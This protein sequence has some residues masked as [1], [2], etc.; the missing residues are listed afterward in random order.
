MIVEEVD[1]P[2]VKLDD[3]ESF[4]LTC[5][6][7]LAAATRRL[8]IHN[9][10]RRQWYHTRVGESFTIRSIVDL[11]SLVL[12]E[13]R[14][15]PFVRDLCIYDWH[16]DTDDCPCD[17]D[18]CQCENGR[19]RSKV[20]KQLT[21]ALSAHAKDRVLS[22]DD[23]RDY[24]L[25]PRDRT[26]KACKN[27]SKTLMAY[28]LPNVA[29][30]EWSIDMIDTACESWLRKGSAS[31]SNL[32]PGWPLL[33]TVNA[34]LHSEGPL[35][36][37]FKPFMRS[38]KLKTLIGENFWAWDEDVTRYENGFRNMFRKTWETQD[39]NIVF[40]E[41]YIE[42]AQIGLLLRDF[43]G[44]QLLHSQHDP[45]GMFGA[46][47]ENPLEFCP[48]HLVESIAEQ[49]PNLLILKL[50]HEPSVSC[51]IRKSLVQDCAAFKKLEHLDIP[52]AWIDTTPQSRLLPR[53]ED[54]ARSS[55][56]DIK[57]KF[58]ESLPPTLKHLRID[59]R[60]LGRAEC[61]LTMTLEELD[62]GQ[63]NTRSKLLLL[64]ESISTCRNSL[65]LLTQI[66]VR[67]PQ[68]RISSTMINML[69]GVTIKRLT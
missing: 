69:P 25:L 55:T 48:R 9:R 14:V 21:E 65:K 62:C 22:M 4:A 28:L 23:F 33:E 8:D 26:Q 3:F 35:Q 15:G 66:E 20:E 60:D 32:W 13:P 17:T 52:L 2:Q 61:R 58:V 34:G 7:I 57:L 29:S 38:P 24:L 16:C 5:K 37:A 1:A 41:S 12:R 56:A 27:A 30:L 46:D 50:I 63:T 36:V 11:V 53:G 42:P 68:M 40:K 31:A 59:A 47:N 6:A 45:C 49:T 10:L 18:D 54:G 39:Q 64:L 51:P 67:M 19:Q 43:P 44:L